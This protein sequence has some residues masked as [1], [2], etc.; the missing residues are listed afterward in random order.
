MGSAPANKR[1]WTCDATYVRCQAK[2]ENNEIVDAFKF[3]YI[4]GDSSGGDGYFDKKYFPYK[5]KMAQKK[6][7][8]PVVAV[9]VLGEDSNGLAVSI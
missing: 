3:Q 7:E 4:G 8:S 2:D 1:T 9:K 6:Y 5:G